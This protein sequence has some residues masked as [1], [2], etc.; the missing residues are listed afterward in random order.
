[1][2]LINIEWTGLIAS[3]S[4]APFLEGCANL[5]EMEI[6]CHDTTSMDSGWDIPPLCPIHWSVLGISGCGLPDY[7]GKQLYFSRSIPI[8]LSVERAH[9]GQFDELYRRVSRVGKLTN[10]EVI[11]LAIMVVTP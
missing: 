3:I 1:L 2:Q 8:V 4:V 6:H 10:L 7:P 9:F 11:N 5:K